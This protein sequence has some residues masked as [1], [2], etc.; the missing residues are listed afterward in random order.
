M[1]NRDRSN[2]RWILNVNRPLISC[3]VPVFNGEK[4]LA[5]ALDSILAQ[6]YRPLEVIVPDDGST[7]GTAALAARYRDRIRYVR[8]DNAGAPAARNLGLSIA[9]GEFVAFLDSDD[10]WHPEKLQRQME[11]FEARPELDLSLTYLQ[12]FWISELEKEKARFQDHRLA[13]ALPG[14]VTQTLLARRSA[15]DKVGLFNDSLRVGDPA[16]WFLRASEVG[17]VTEMITDILVYRR[18][19]ESNM[20]MQAA[21]RRMTSP[22]QDA[23]L[24]VVKA[25]L[26]RRRQSGSGVVLLNVPNSRSE[27]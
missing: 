21:T 13:G 24:R 11:R 9:K 10:L 20:S 7:D 5:E 22:M 14:Y 2:D 3:I 23:I 6:T 8:Q 18:M 27:K 25:S 15:F 1:L 19:H 16:D 12:N 4:Y 26:D 17:L